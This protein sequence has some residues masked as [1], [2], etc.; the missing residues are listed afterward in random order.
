MEKIFALNLK[1]T[2]KAYQS[3]F[4]MIKAP[5]YK[6]KKI[7]HLIKCLAWRQDRVKCTTLLQGR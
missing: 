1:K 4:K 5:K 2:A 7:S 6:A 3:N